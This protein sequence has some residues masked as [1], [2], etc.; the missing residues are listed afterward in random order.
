MSN[1]IFLMDSYAQFI[2][3]DKVQYQHYPL[4]GFLVVVRLRVEAVYLQ[5]WGLLYFEEI[6][7]LH[8]KLISRTT[9]TMISKDNADAFRT[10]M[11]EHSSSIYSY[12]LM[13]VHHFLPV[14]KKE[15]DCLFV[16]HGDIISK[17][18][19]EHD[20]ED[21]YCVNSSLVCN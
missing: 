15:N 8:K 9:G 11:Y 18:I 10:I 14:I 2:S 20:K 16:N 19:N 6:L 21:S 5:I 4:L 7:A 3:E 12:F 13:V 17:D 1:A